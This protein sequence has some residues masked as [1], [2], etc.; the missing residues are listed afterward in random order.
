MVLL[1]RVALGS[2]VHKGIK[3]IL[4]T[5]KRDSEKQ[6][7]SMDLFPHNEGYSLILLLFPCRG[8]AV[9]SSPALP[10]ISFL[11]NREMV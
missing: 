6:S 7:K 10:A 4:S 8:R 2:K 3:E 9:G 5:V 1:K 11:K